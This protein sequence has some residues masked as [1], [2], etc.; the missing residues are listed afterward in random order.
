MT[1]T[2]TRTATISKWN[3]TAQKRQTLTLLTAHRWRNS[4]GVRMQTGG[5]MGERYGE[6]GRALIC[7][8]AV[9]QWSVNSSHKPWGLSPDTL[10]PLSGCRHSPGP[11]HGGGLRAKATGRV[12]DAWPE[13]HAHTHSHL[14]GVLHRCASLPQ[15]GRSCSGYCWCG[16]CWVLGFCCNVSGFVHWGGFVLLQKSS[17]RGQEV[18]QTAKITCSLLCG[19]SKTCWFQNCILPCHSYYSCHRKTW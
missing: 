18:Y 15:I 13:G 17:K 3:D 11:R 19:R 1:S 9:H 5:G 12:N 16:L 2:L 14:L 4:I 10:H 7:Q 6:T 8:A